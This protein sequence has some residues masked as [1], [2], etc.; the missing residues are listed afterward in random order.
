M[1]KEVY[2]GYVHKDS[3]TIGTYSMES[4]QKLAIYNPKPEDT[5]VII[6]GYELCNGAEWQDFL[7]VVNKLGQENQ[8]LKSMWERLGNGLLD[9]LYELEDL[10]G[11]EQLS[12]I[13]VGKLAVTRAVLNKMEEL[14]KEL[15][16]GTK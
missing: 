10:D 8:V 1:S 4:K 12:D 14:E 13:G 11:G 5:K 7:D 15:K 6:W 3:Q 2:A 16:D 9:Y